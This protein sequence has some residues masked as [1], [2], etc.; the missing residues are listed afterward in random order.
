MSR[1]LPIGVKVTIIINIVSMLL[2]ILTGIFLVMIAV[3]NFIKAAQNAGT[4]ASTAILIFAGVLS[5]LVGVVPGIILF[6]INRGLRQLKASSRVWQIIMSCFLFLSFPAG[7]ILN[8]VILYFM[9]F[10]SKT[11]AAFINVE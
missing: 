10:D 11:K 5:F 6:F 8:A 4:Q 2:S 7:T 1:E 3:P 9:L